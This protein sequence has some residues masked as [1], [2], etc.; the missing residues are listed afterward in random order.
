MTASV[1]ARRAISRVVGDD[2]ENRLA[3]EHHALGGK[4]RLIGDGRAKIV[5][6]R[7]IVAAMTAWTPGNARTCE[8]KPH[9]AAARHRRAADRDMQRSLGFA[10]VVDIVGGAL[11]MLERAVV[12]H[13][14]GAHDAGTACLVQSAT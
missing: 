10:D 8:I 5:L 9:D 11:H 2:R 4:R 3:M 1:A 6:A 7:N 13:A 14:P 12:R